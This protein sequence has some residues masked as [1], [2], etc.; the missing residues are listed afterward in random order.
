MLHGLHGEPRR[1]G[2]TRLFSAPIASRRQH[3]L[4]AVRGG[5]DAP[6]DALGIA[7]VATGDAGVARRSRRA[8]GCPPYRP[9]G[10]ESTGRFRA[11][12]DPWVDSNPISLR[13]AKPGVKG[14]TMGRIPTDHPTDIPRDLPR[15]QKAEHPND[16][17]A[18]H[19]NNQK[20]EHP[21]DQKAELRYAARR[22]GKTIRIPPSPRCIARCTSTFIQ[23]ARER[24][25]SRDYRCAQRAARAAKQNIRAKRGRYASVES[26][27]RR[28]YGC[29]QCAAQA[30]KQN[31]RAKR[32][33]YASAESA[34]R[35]DYGCAQRAA[36]PRE[37]NPSEARQRTHDSQNSTG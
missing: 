29:A 18:E 28:D 22:D 24:G 27:L 34:L 4:R 35:R 36:K 25:G 20:A 2:A 1:D 6:A 33:R 26:A 37:N 10:F 30:A 21:N 31:T 13:P 15:D 11:P 3:A 16:Q 23:R 7:C 12:R 9:P 5:A 8:S 32:G 14:Q 17:K 19:P